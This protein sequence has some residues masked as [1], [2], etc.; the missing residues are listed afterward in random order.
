MNTSLRE[1]HLSSQVVFRDWIFREGVAGH[2]AHPRVEIGCCLTGTT[3]YVI[4]ARRFTIQP[5]AAIV[6]PVEVEHA[7]A[8]TQAGTR[9]RSIHV[10]REMFE[11][12]ADAVGTRVHE[13]YVVDGSAERPSTL[14]ALASLLARETEQERPGR[15][16]AVEALTDAVV[17]ES[18]R[19]GKPW[20]P[21]G[22]DPRI[23]QA[24]DLIHER[25]ASALTLDELAGAAGVSRFHFVRLFRAE[26]GKTPFRY[27]LDVRLSRAARLLRTRACSVTEAALSVGCCDLGDSA[28]ASGRSSVSPE[29]VPAA[30]A[31]RSA[32]GTGEVLF[33]SSRLSDVRPGPRFLVLGLAPEEPAHPLREVVEER[34]GDGRRQQ[35]QRAA[36]GPARRRPRRRWRG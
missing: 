22:R 23:R 16:L 7:T 32:C 34:V 35:R 29:R 17:V 36:R 14:V 9:V 4:A 25:Y 31:K 28:G 12:A 19:A 8:A 27:L 21:S 20:T 1:R 13:P 18:L 30:R 6:I 5:G 15:A 3:E 10:A 33:A 24:V 2:R 26:T 11:T